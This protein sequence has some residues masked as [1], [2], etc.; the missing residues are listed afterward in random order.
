MA[1]AL[2]S[3]LAMRATLPLRQETSRIAEERYDVA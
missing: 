1:M 2:V 3:A